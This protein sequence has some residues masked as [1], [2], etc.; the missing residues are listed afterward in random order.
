MA[1]NGYDWPSH[2]LSNCEKFKI[3]SAE[4]RA[5]KIESLDGSALCTSSQHKRDDCNKLQ[6]SCGMGDGSNLCARLHH[7]ML[8]G[9]KVTYVNCARGRV[10]VYQGAKE[11]PV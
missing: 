5:K 9:T 2:R 1:R 8:H 3:L 4:D 6:K 10:A 11:V 7:R